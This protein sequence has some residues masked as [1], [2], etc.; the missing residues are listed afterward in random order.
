MIEQVR[1]ALRYPLPISPNRETILMEL[2]H[3]FQRL[4]NR[5][6]N[7]AAPWSLECT[8]VCF[9]A[10]EEKGEIVLAHNVGIIQYVHT[11]PDDTTQAQREIKLVKPQ[12]LDQFYSGPLKATGDTVYTAEVMAPYYQQGVLKMMVRPVPAVDAIYRLWYK[13]GVYDAGGLA[14]EPA[15]PMFHP[16]IIA[17]AARNLTYHCEWEGLDDPKLRQVRVADITAAQNAKYEENNR[18]FARYIAQLD[19]ARP[20]RRREFGEEEYNRWS[21]AGTD[22]SALWRG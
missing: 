9:Q 17:D 20:R 7:R 3:S 19:Q 5:L 1:I 4:S 2:R 13:P 10:G 14:S 11:I 15:L 18:D 21:D 8:D 12:N 6:T 22:M 16:M